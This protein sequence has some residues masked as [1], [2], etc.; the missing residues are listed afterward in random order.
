MIKQVYDIASAVHLYCAQYILLLA[1]VVPLVVRMQS[2]S[3]N[4][5]ECM[6]HVVFCLFALPGF[7]LQLMSLNDVANVVVQDLAI[8]V[9]I[10]CISKSCMCL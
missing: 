9:C 10:A 7:C 8:F 1:A 2:L 5:F 6:A 4:M 3:Y